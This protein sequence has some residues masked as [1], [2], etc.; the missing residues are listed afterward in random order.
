LL[1]RTVV[2]HSLRRGGGAVLVTVVIPAFLRLDLVRFLLLRRRRH[3][4][5]VNVHFPEPEVKWLSRH[6]ID[7]HRTRGQSLL[8]LTLLKMARLSGRQNDNTRWRRNRRQFHLSQNNWNN[9]RFRDRRRH[10][11]RRENRNYHLLPVRCF[12]GGSS[13]AWSFREV[14]HHHLLL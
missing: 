6:L 7:V 3:H 8:V 12:G 5:G 14:N 11:G 10:N 4:R 1:V 2:F 13:T 9:R